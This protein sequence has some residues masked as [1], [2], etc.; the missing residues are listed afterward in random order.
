MD[1]TSTI[2]VNGIPVYIRTAGHQ[3][4]KAI[5]F[6][7]GSSQQSAIW[8][9]QLTD[10]ILKQQFK[11]IALDLPG[12]GHSGHSAAPEQHYSIEGMAGLIAGCL[13]ELSLQHYLLAGHSLGT[14]IISEA[15]PYLA[16]P[17]RGLFFA[18][19]TIANK[20]NPPAAFLR[21]SPYMH[22]RVTASPSE[23][24]LT[25][26]ARQLA[27]KATDKLVAGC[28]Q[29]FNDTDPA[30]RTVLGKCFEKGMYNNEIAGVQQSKLPLCLVMGLL[31][32]VSE[33]DYLDHIPFRQKWKDTIYKVPAAGHLVN[34]DQP[35]IFN[36]LLMQFATGV[37]NGEK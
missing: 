9:Q 3:S 37:L 24:E 34:C 2:P 27:H 25:A 19:A 6:I 15:L 5:V 22:V 1:N 7:H 14:N 35:Q 21:K 10:H 4:G 8:E 17:P 28:K 13:N 30:V 18:S 33:P 11:L 32:E 16:V 36:H 20:E 31:D 29:Y 12:H 23:E 26:Y